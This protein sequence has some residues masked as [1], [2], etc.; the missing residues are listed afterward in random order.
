MMSIKDYY[1][2]CCHVYISSFS[3]H[4]SEKFY[5]TDTYTACGDYVSW[6]GLK[7]HY[8]S[9]T[10]GRRHDAGILRESGLL[11]ELEQHCNTPDGETLCMYGGRILRIRIKEFLHKRRLTLL[12]SSCL[13]I[14]STIP[15]I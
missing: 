8:F 11:E 15:S 13:F 2:I 1:C 5:L 6:Y 7:G 12:Y 3:R 10:E 9:S 4:R 14:C